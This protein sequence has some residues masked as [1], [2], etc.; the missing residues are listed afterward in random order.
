MTSPLSNATIKE[1]IRNY[2]VEASDIIILIVN[3]I[4]CPV[5]VVLNLMVI[6]AVKRRRRLQTNSNIL[7]A[8]LA[9][10]D[11][12]T[13][14]ITQPAFI[15]WRTFEM[16]GVIVYSAAYTIHVKA[17]GVL[18]V[19]SCLHLMLVTGERLVAIKFTMHYLHIVTTKNITIAVTSCWIVSVIFQ[20]LKSFKST[21][22]ASVFFS[23]LVIGSCVVFVASAY[24]ALYFEVRRYQKLIKGQQMPQEEAERFAKENK[25]LKTAIYIVGAL[26]LCLTPAVAVGLTFKITER[27]EVALLYAW[28]RTIVMSNSLLNPLLYCWRQK[29]LR[30]YLF[31]TTLV[32][33]PVE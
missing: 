9:A 7:L 2:Q 3:S 4:S 23:L 18:S 19:C 29:P 30:Q 25:A 22:D 5:T 11:T 14:L 27:K 6:M 32:V 10:T 26:V 12:L 15:L 21:L 24:V 1:K 28:I 31:K 20:V 8:C 17:I 16:T 13:G 33:H